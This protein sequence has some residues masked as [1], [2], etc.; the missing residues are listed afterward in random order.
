[1]RPSTLPRPMRRLVRYYAL[2]DATAGPYLS[3]EQM[4]EGVEALG[5]TVLSQ[6]LRA[7]VL[8]PINP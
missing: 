2:G 5:V 6:G 1:M 4:V 3:G 8:P 7:I